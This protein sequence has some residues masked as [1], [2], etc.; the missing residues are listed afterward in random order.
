LKKNYN[1]DIIIKNGNLNDI[2]LGGE[3]GFI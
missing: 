2:I 3:Y 1:C